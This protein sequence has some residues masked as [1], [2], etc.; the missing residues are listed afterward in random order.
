M[1]LPLVEGGQLWHP[2]EEGAW[3]G[4]MWSKG[5]MI[6]CCKYVST[7]DDGECCGGKVSLFVLIYVGFDSRGLA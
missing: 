5:C 7:N 1:L 3:E 6:V 4:P 2:Y